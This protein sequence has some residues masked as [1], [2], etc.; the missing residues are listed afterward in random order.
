MKS[1]IFLDITP[2]SPLK[3]N[4][5]LRGT[6]SLHLQGRR[7]SQHAAG[8]KQNRFLSDYMSLYLRI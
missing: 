6:C 8:S 5:R 3:I 1:P 2:C 7:M 4:R